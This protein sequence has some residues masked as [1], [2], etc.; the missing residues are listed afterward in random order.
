MSPEITQLLKKT[1]N[2]WIQT[3][4]KVYYFK[5]DNILNFYKNKKTI[6]LGKVI[7]R[8]LCKKL[9]FDQKKQMVYAQLKSFLVN[10][11]R[12]ILWYFVIQTDHLIQVRRPELLLFVIVK[13]SLNYILSQWTGR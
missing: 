7:H 6:I 5:G 9:K 2:Y 12:K 3:E 13:M 1:K 11:T 4:E 8:E 10:E